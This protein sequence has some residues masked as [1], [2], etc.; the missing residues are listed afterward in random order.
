MGSPKAMVSFAVP[1][2]HTVDPRDVPLQAS[3]RSHV[4]GC[5]TYSALQNSRPVSN[6][7]RYDFF[8]Y[9]VTCKQRFL[10]PQSGRGSTSPDRR[11]NNR[12]IAANS[13]FLRW[14]GVAYPHENFSS[15]S[16]LA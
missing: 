16:P 8:V 6:K 7:I 12:R 11:L 13:S 1:E 2:C 10:G 9:T 4:T 5:R 15:A 14:P 3:S